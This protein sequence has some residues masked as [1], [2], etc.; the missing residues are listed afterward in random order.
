MGRYRRFTSSKTQAHED[1]EQAEHPGSVPPPRALATD[2]RA[3]ILALQHTAGNRA[4]SQ[5]L[6]PDGS[7]S[8]P[9]GDGAPPSVQD[10]LR[11]S[12]R[13]LDGAV[14]VFMESRFN[15][16]FS[17][18]RVHADAQ[19]AR[20]AQ[21]LG[22]RAYTV[23]QN[24]AFGEG[25]YA[26]ETTA[27]RQLLAHE[28]THVVQQGGVSAT[29]AQRG[30]PAGDSSAAAPLEH[31]AS[32]VA[33]GIE[34]GPIPEAPGPHAAPGM[35]LRDQDPKASAGSLSTFTVKIG[36]QDKAFAIQ[37]GKQPDIYKDRVSIRFA[38]LRAGMKNPPIADRTMVLAVSP[39][40]TLAPKIIDES[41]MEL[42]EGDSFQ[43]TIHI[44]LNPADPDSAA[45]SVILMYSSGRR[46]IPV[47]SPDWPAQQVVWK[48]VFLEDGWVGASD[49]LHEIAV[50]FPAVHPAESLFA[51][52]T[53]E[54]I[55]PRLGRGRIHP[56]RGFV[57]LTQEPVF[58]EAF[59]EAGKET[60]RLGIHLIPVVGSLVMIGEALVGKD[61]WGRP[62]SMTERAILGAGA[63]LAE[64]GPLIRVGRAAAAASRLSRVAGISGIE[65]VRMVFASRAL[66]ATDRAALEKL[67]AKV[68]AGKAL[69]EAEEALANRLIGK[70]GET[71]R[72]KAVRAEV[73][74][75]T[76]AARKPGRFTNL[77]KTISA[78][79]QRVGEA[80]ARD[81]KADV[82]RPP[83]SVVSGVKNPDYVLDDAVAELYSPTTGNVENLIRGAVKKHKQAGTMVVDLT[84]SAVTPEELLGAAGR[85]FGR[86]EFSDVGRLI[87]VQG[88]KVVGQALRPAAGSAAPTIIR[89]TASAA[90]EKAGREEPPERRVPP[91][92][93]EAK[94][95]APAVS[96]GTLSTF[97]ISLGGTERVVAFQIGKQPDFQSNRLSIRFA[98]LQ[99]EFRN[100]D[101]AERT[102]VLAVSPTVALSP[103]IVEES[104]V[105]DSSRKL[106]RVSLNGKKSGTSEVRIAVAK[107]ADKI[108]VHATDGTNSITI[109]FP[110]G[111]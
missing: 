14:R 34:N 58:T 89:G 98:S 68:R 100:P 60:V 62:L 43:K 9:Q 93:A 108:Y 52:G 20:S 74:A 81:L 111:G 59:V 65:A 54:F 2:P 44:S 101:I 67:A 107:L 87:V 47:I 110:R 19:A 10:V 83:E 94:R 104:E 32:A 70:M 46:K 45:V 80:L 26:P 61:I 76:G 42:P 18:V 102:M 51:E 3:G 27:G 109:N 1:R 41:E 97:F 13:P 84:R 37:I 40:A 57:P 86:P 78:E 5:L 30:G 50:N 28:L 99:R 75:V 4:V 17:R 77:G 35:I 33:R 95:G 88:E 12:G 71:A 73:E 36:G 7:R 66:T 53:R 29:P 38:S 56:K 39:K 22:A 11:S 106:I 48:N 31:E 103:R 16:D 90:A 91:T 85:F 24:I 25:Q 72:V 82:V 15:H 64:I 21:A 69:T 49:G 8:V 79:E 96:A 6:R 92:T 63:L 23:G 105:G 55:H